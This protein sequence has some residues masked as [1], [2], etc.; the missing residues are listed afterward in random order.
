MAS[1]AQSCS[2]RLRITSRPYLQGT[3]TRYIHRVAW[4]CPSHI[5]KTCL[6]EVLLYYQQPGHT[7][8]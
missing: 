3:S 2:C 5:A 1:A 7:D 4:G 8:T 6:L